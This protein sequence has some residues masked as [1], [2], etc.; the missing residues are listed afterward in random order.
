MEK[1]VIFTVIFG[2][3]FNGCLKITPQQSSIFDVNI[4][5]IFQYVLEKKE[6]PDFEEKYL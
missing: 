3:L 1:E 5:I 6:P 4:Y 2:G